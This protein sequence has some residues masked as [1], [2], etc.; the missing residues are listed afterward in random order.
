MTHA[1]QPHQVRPTSDPISFLSLSRT[2]SFR[3]TILGI[4]SD[5]GRFFLGFGIL[6]LR[7]IRVVDTA[8]A[9]R[10]LYRDVEIQWQGLG[11]LPR[12]SLETFLALI[13]S[14]SHMR[15]DIRRIWA[16]LILS[17]QRGDTVRDTLEIARLTWTHDE[18]VRFVQYL[19][20]IKLSL[21]QPVIDTRT[22]VSV[23]DLRT[24][25]GRNWKSTIIN[26]LQLVCALIHVNEP[27]ILNEAFTS[28]DLEMVTLIDLEPFTPPQ[29]S[30]ISWDRVSN[31]E[32]LL[33]G[34][35]MVVGA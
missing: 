19:G 1:L 26:T 18:L 25:A 21:S 27:T 7:G 24:F 22:L 13:K 14:P 10:R 11:P 17:I 35:Q 16:L 15:I 4:G 31:E 30:V 32:L 34:L 23:K 29:A 20:L 3:S 28:S 6:V 9:F 33:P 5:S 2:S 8:M 12:A